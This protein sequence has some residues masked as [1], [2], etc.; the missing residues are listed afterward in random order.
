MPLARRSTQLLLLAA[1]TIS[2]GACRKKGADMP[3]D[4]FIAVLRPLPT[5]DDSLFDPGTLRGKPTLVLFASP[6]C[7]HCMVELPVAEK[8]AA[9]ERANMVAVFIVGNKKHAAAVKKSKHLVSPVLVDEDGALRAKYNIKGVPYTIVL[10]PDGR[11]IEAF[12]GEQ[13]EDVLREALA[14]AR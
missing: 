13:G 10:G 9:A 8:A 1:L 2:A 5:A 7:S 12:R 14:D 3:S 11:A 4:D 6:T